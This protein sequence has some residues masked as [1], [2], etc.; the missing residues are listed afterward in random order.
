[1]PILREQIKE[2]PRNVL[3]LLVHQRQGVPDVADTAGTSDAVHVVVDIVREVVVDHLSHVGDVQPT[4][5]DVCGD[6]HRAL[7]CVFRK[8]GGGKGGREGG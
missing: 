2:L 8:G 1:M 3:V 6:E 5:R 4:G 7:A